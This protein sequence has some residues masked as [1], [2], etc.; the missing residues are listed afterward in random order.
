MIDANKRFTA[1]HHA[2]SRIG[3]ILVQ[4]DLE[5]HLS[6]L[7]R[8][9][10]DSADPLLQSLAKESLMRMIQLVTCLLHAKKAREEIRLHVDEKV[11]HS[12]AIAA[13]AWVQNLS[14]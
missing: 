5:S 6:D 8:A 11:N 7:Q 13:I 2:V 4:M 12:N 9:Y 10:S 1:T 14:V 3:E